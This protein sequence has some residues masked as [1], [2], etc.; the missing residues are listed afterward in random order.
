MAHSVSIVTGAARQKAPPQFADWW[1][2]FVDP[3]AR[4]HTLIPFLMR[5][6]GSRV[7]V[8]DLCAGLGIEA[9][10]LAAANKQV[11]ANELDPNFG[12]I[13]RHNVAATQSSLRTTRVDWRRLNLRFAPSSFEAALMLGNSLCLLLDVEDQRRA[14]HQ[15]AALIEPGGLLCI[16][17]RNFERVLSGGPCDGAGAFPYSR[18]VMYCGK[19]VSGYPVRTS[20]QKVVFRYED[21]AGR[22]L[23]VLEMLPM[24]QEHMVELFE[25]ACLRHV[26]SHYDLDTARCSE[27]SDFVT[28]LFERS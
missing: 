1:S 25:S 26:S 12:R 2:D 13:L 22:P 28:H 18:R 21:G 16:D 5:V 11:T 10:A 27:E 15:I 7:K 19:G 9:L 24:L 8:L 17:R 20:V 14:A 6:I 23:G 3:D 4:S